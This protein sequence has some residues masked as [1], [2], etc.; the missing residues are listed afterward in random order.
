MAEGFRG[1]QKGHPDF[2]SPETRKKAGVKIGKAHKGT[3]R[4]EESKKK[5]SES[6]IGHIP[7]NKGK[8]GIYS[9]DTKERMGSSWRGKKMP[10][11][12]GLKMSISRMGEKNHNW[13]G[14]KSFEPYSVDWTQTLKRSIRERDHYTCQLCG[15]LQGDIAHDVHHIDY[16]KKNCDPKNLITLCHSCNAKVNVDRE[17]WINY[18]LLKKLK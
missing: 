4:S 7:W 12:T 2:V 5:M 1:F 15:K 8:E 17:Y 6:H 11:G 10:R 16:N 3:H 9:E 18:F 14:G 13:L